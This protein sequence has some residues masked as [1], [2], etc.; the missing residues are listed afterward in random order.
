MQDI[1]W[2]RIKDVYLMMK[3]TVDK[4][5]RNLEELFQLK[6]SRVKLRWYVKEYQIL[7]TEEGELHDL[8]NRAEIS[9]AIENFKKTML[10]YEQ[11]VQ[12]SGTEFR[13]EIRNI[14]GVYF[15][16]DSSRPADEQIVYVGLAKS[17][18]GRLAGHFWKTEKQF[19]RVFYEELEEKELEATESYYIW[20]LRYPLYNKDAGKNDHIVRRLLTVA[21]LY[22]Q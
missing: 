7:K 3:W 16:I 21:G 4:A 17:I 20:H 22:D 12:M 9:E 5:T 13:Q 2:K 14:S 15:L 1:V 8:T 6:D 18:M 10:T 19:D 11:I